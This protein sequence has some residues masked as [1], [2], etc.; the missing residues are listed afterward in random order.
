M[1]NYSHGGFYFESNC[2]LHLGSHLCVNRAHSS[3]GGYQDETYKVH[4]TEVKWC[5]KLLENNK[6]IYG[7]GVKY[8]DPIY[9]QKIDAP[10][11][12]Y[13]DSPNLLRDRLIKPSG[14]Q[15]IV[16][17]YTE[18]EKKDLDL[19]HAKELAETRANNLAVLNQLATA[20]SSTLDLD[21][22]LKGICKE[23]VEIFSARNTG[24]CLL[25]EERTKIKLV[26]FHTASEEDDAM[27]L[28]LLLE[29]NAATLLVLETGQSIVVPDVQNN[30]I[31][32]SYHHISR[33]RG[34]QCIMIV[35]LMA[36]GEVI[37]T[38]GIPTSDK[39]RIFTY[40]EV[41]LAQTIAGQI[42]SAIHNARLYAE[43]QRD[44]EMGRQIQA[45]FF[46]Q[47]L[48]TLHSWEIATHFQPARQVAGDFYDVF[49]LPNNQV[50]F[51]IADVCDKGVGAA[52]FTGLIRCLIRIF[53]GSTSLYGLSFISDI[54][55][56][57]SV[58]SSL[59]SE[60]ENK[61][62][63]LKAVSAANDYIT[64]EHDQLSMFISLFFG[65]LNPD[66]DILTYINSGHEPPLIISSSGG[67]KQKL[68]STGP[69]VG[70][71]PNA[72]FKTD[73]VEIKPGD[74]LIGYTDGV[75]EALS[76][77]GELFTKKRFLSLFE[78]PSV[79]A[80]SLLEKIKTRLSTHI[81]TAK[82]FDDITIIVLR[83]LLKEEK[84]DQR[85]PTSLG[86]ISNQQTDPGA[87]PNYQ[88]GKLNGGQGKGT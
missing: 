1:V 35:P 83:R 69:V 2:A 42:A 34:T 20:V 30:P 38:I 67:I 85:S 14:I 37:G 13:E 86:G 32:E 80:S 61:K 10:E 22:I 87:G 8:I 28:E 54:T 18:Q 5:Q 33:K 72:K 43:T 23:M 29:G 50:G 65:I 21:K 9:Y 41:S 51:V 19:Q 47:R 56:A 53:S 15:E 6:T 17:D 73:Q 76:P 81:D 7:V 62:N 68:K 75:I 60:D 71:T 31:T 88:P 45:G 59:S 52:L 74:I 82:Q 63:A 12:I 66:T 77:D 3:P 4:R 84:K 79:S 55:K 44:L 26:A 58:L 48:P 39:D 36:R 46:P 70:M 11:E 49:H 57:D 25:N 16:L 78:Q 27:G 40:E 64:N 24:I